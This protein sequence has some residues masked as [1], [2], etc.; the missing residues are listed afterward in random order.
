[1]VPHRLHLVHISPFAHIPNIVRLGAEGLAA[2]VKIKLRQRDQYCSSHEKWI[3]CGQLS[4]SV[5]V[6][7]KKIG[8][9]LE[10][11]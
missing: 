11:C 2:F 6:R 7:I 8:H 3:I 9:F 10:C 4:D 5:I 1:M